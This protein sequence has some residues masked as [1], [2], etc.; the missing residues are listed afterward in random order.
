M[1]LNYF[2]LGTDYSK[3]ALEDLLFRGT[4]YQHM[5][6]GTSTGVDAITLEDVQNHYKKYF[7]KD[8]L[9]IG[10]AGNYNEAF[11]NTLLSD[12]SQLPSLKVTLPEAPD[13]SMPDGLH[14]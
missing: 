8:N 7:T 11:K 12:A 3:L 5:I 2:R 6:M 10:I 13:V 1:M 9:F 14:I 4:P